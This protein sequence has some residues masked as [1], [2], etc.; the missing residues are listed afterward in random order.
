M[1]LGID[2]SNI[3]RGGGVT[4]LVEFLQ[5]ARPD[6]QGID[7]VIV[8]SGGAT[9]SQIK[10]KPWLTLVHDPVLDR[11]L[12]FRW[13]WQRFVLPSMAQHQ[14]DVLFVPGE[15]RPMSLPVVTMCQNML[16]FQPEDAVLWLVADAAQA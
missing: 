5:A 12:P 15:L 3:R 8:W 14:C 6:L 2:A 13:H 10:P 4:H 16:P 1:R 11:S 9:L 7:Q